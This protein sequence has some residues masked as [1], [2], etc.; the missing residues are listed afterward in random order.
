LATSERLEKSM[1]YDGYETHAP[2]IYKKL[3][4][5]QVGVATTGVVDPAVKNLLAVYMAQSLGCAFCAD[6]HTQYAGDIPTSKLTC[7]PAFREARAMYSEAEYTALLF[8]E[9]VLKY[10]RD[11]K[12]RDES[13]FA[14]V[15]RV[16][17]PAG[18]A[19]LM[20]SATMSITWGVSNY[21]FEVGPGEIKV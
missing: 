17:S 10:I 16:F 4:D 11:G 12:A 20:F 5:V 18:L 15:V 21:V 6:L 1:K 2:K 13:F 7:L 9:A 19:E 8:G 14:E 3:L